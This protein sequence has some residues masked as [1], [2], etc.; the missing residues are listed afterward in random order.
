MPSL[1]VLEWLSWL[2]LWDFARTAG[3]V[4]G[5]AEVFLVAS[6]TDP[7]A[8]FGTADSGLPMKVIGIVG[9]IA[10]GKS[11]VAKCFQRLGAVVLD[12]DRIGHNVLQLDSVKSA[13]RELLGKTVFDSQ[14]EVVRSAVA[15]RVFGLDSASRDRL[16]RLE[17][18]THPLIAEQMR[19]EIQRLRLS[20]NVPAVVL[21]APVLIKAGWDRLCDRIVFVE[22]DAKTRQRRALNRGWSA[23]EWRRRESLQTPLVQV[24]Q[25]ADSV[26]DNSATPESIERQVTEIWRQW[27][28]PFATLEIPSDPS[29]D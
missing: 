7:V 14:G 27:G 8:L 26:I 16:S 23:D 24:R 25:L 19:D 28:L 22:A 3:E 2:D 21:D 12:A 6:A 18:I 29:S 5:N 20:K 9:G 11:L 17:Q 13:I 4:H 15:D 10:S 1:R